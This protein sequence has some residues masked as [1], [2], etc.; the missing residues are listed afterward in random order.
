[1]SLSR[2]IFF[3][4][5]VVSFFATS[6]TIISYALGYRWSSDRGVFVYA[7]SLTIVSNPEDIDVSV[8]NQPLA[9]RLNYLNHSY[10][11][12]GMRPDQ[13]IVQV[14]AP[15]FQPWSKKITINSGVSTEFWNVLLVRDLYTRT[16]Y[17]VENVRRFFIAPQKS[18]LVTV[19]D[20]DQKLTL[21]LTNHD[22]QESQQLFSTNDYHFV[23]D[24][25]KNIEW[26]PQ[27]HRMIV[28][29]ISTTETSGI[30]SSLLSSTDAIDDYLVVTVDTGEYLSLRSLLGLPNFVPIENV[31]WH[32]KKRDVVYYLLDNILYRASVGGSATA[33]NVVA[34]N[35]SAYDFSDDGLTY[36]DATTLILYHTDDIESAQEP[37]Q[38]T[39]AQP[40]LSDSSYRL[41]SYDKD[42]ATLLNDSG[43]LYL[44]NRSPKNGVFFE[45]IA[46]NVVGTHFS[47]DG[48][49]LLYWNE[50]E[51]F[52][53]FTRDWDTQPSRSE[54]EHIAITRFAQKLR[55]VQWSVSYEQVIFV[56]GN[57]VKVIELDNRDH[58]N[59]FTIAH[60]RS[61]DSLA[62]SDHSNKMLFFTDYQPGTRISTLQSIEFPEK[63]GFFNF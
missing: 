53:Y 42:R 45:K 29:V 47:N 3:W 9:G 8:N 58:R 30:A 21:T 34:T 24:I 16:T 50:N 28:P 40:D 11:I 35:V 36:L 4:L 62:V 5:L 33:I 38:I 1:M 17:D 60:L 46:D 48:K 54:G 39:T 10:H 43:T 22:T 56:V 31:R 57:E 32:P 19:G 44:F 51:I 12:S 14:T 63:T 15:E 59:V 25:Q 37:I 7:G 23:S 49:K 26:S 20:S 27:A 41:I 52:A 13:Y 18:R 2:R 55:S 6:S 61:S